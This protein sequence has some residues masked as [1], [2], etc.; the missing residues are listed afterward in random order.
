MTCPSCHI[1]GSRS[2]AA[3]STTI[4][5]TRSL[6]PTSHPSSHGGII[7][8]AVTARDS[9]PVASSPRP[10]SSGRSETVLPARSGCERRAS[11]R[12]EHIYS[13]YHQLFGT[14]WLEGWTLRLANYIYFVPHEVYILFC[15]TTLPIRAACYLSCYRAWCLVP[16]YGQ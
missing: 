13:H 14:L 1:T 6:S 16:G 8:W 12:T 3:P 7:Y 15:L 4:C 10:C 11:S 9:W 2:G 5:T